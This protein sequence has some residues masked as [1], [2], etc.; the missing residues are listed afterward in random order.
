MITLEKQKITEC[1]LEQI[2]NAQQDVDFIRTQGLNGEAEACAVV[3]ALFK[4]LYE[5]LIPIVSVKVGFSE[6]KMFRNR[7]FKTLREM[8]CHFAR[9]NDIDAGY[10]KTDV[11]I[12]YSDG[13]E[14]SRRC[15]VSAID[16]ASSIHK[17]LLK[18]VKF[19]AGMRKPSH[20]TDAQYAQCIDAQS[21]KEF[22]RI[23]YTYQLMTD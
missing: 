21:I 13:F 4:A 15:D 12:K 3:R 10:Y 6:N 17:D 8:A 23:Y 5:N 18:S 14:Y 11:V 1:I 7:E 19:Y 20:L 2:D 22:S 9:H 16:D